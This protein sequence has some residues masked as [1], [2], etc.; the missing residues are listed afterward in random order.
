MDMKK[1]LLTAAVLSLAATAGAATGSHGG[2]APTHFITYANTGLVY[3]YFDATA[4]TN[5]PACGQGNLGNTYNYVFDGTTAAGK[6]MLAGLI[7]V[8]EAGEGVWFSGTGDCGVLAGT[9]T[10]ANFHTQN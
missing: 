8:H 6:S 5:I 4:V 10:L 7:A 1:I 3:V 2:P 9:E